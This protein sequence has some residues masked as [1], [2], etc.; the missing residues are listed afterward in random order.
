MGEYLK[1]CDSAFVTAID[2][3]Q[4]QNHD[5]IVFPNPV[6]GKTFHVNNIYFEIDEIEM[7]SIDG[8]RQDCFFEKNNDNQITVILKTKIPEGAYLLK[9][10][11]GQLIT[12]KKIIIA[13]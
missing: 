1:S 9:L 8:K 3:I 7:I 10:K 13:Q 2:L 6:H 12:S 11:S 4:K 5:L